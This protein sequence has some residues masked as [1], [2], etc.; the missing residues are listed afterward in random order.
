MIMHIDMDAF[1]AA[2]EQEV[3]PSIK[4][5]PVIIGGR[6]NKYKS[7][8]CAAS[9]EAKALGIDSAMPSWRALEICPQAIF[10]P[11]DTAKYLFTA[12]KIFDILK[13]FSPRVEAYS[14]D[15]FFLDCEGCKSFFGSIHNMAGEI[16]KEI[17]KRFG[18]TCSVGVAPTKII[19]KLVAKLGKPDGLTI[20]DK[21]QALSV[22][23]NLPIEK[24]CGIGERLKKRFHHLGIHTCGQLSEY[25]DR[26]LKEHFGVV[27]LW[28][29]QAC[30]LEDTGYVGYHDHASSPKSVGHSQT[31]RECSDDEE[32]IKNWI[33]LLSEMV[34]H[35]LRRL[36]L[37]GRTV[38]FY[39]SDQLLCGWAK[40]KTY[41]EATYDGYEIYQRSLEI[42]RL[43][44]I[45]HLCARVLGVSVSSFQKAD[46]RYLFARQIKRERLLKN[47]DRINERFGE[48]TIF[49]AA[50]T[51][52]EY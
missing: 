35:R 49:P 48:W 25:P 10:V 28:L 24:I 46:N 11:A 13:T 4:G 17:K 15:E 43:L 39:I 32:Y 14:I 20:L 37:Q 7:I 19:A 27:G 2:I 40:Q 38:Y 9:Y 6:N 18:L 16:K 50:L 34:A 26:V 33:Y 23:K 12:E 30:R 47:M 45:K 52:A 51:R 1:F 42:I 5:K 29:K 21:E 3:N 31:L 22:L 44:G 36:E 8:V 41:E